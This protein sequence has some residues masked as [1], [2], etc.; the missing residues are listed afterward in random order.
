MP[1]A[2]TLTCVS[3]PATLYTGPGGGRFCRRPE[4]PLA[5]IYRRN[6]RRQGL[7]ATLQLIS[8]ATSP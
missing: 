1:D 3:R 5:G 8:A 6:R 4:H 7:S 2:H